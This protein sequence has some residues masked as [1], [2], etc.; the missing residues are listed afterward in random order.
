MKPD[1]YEAE[2]LR[3]MNRRRGGLIMRV[4]L[5]H[6]LGPATIT[7]TGTD[8]NESRAGVAMSRAETSDAADGPH[9]RGPDE[10]K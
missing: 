4:D 3:E 1:S 7:T 10:V 5:R 9:G 8:E 2:L 6:L